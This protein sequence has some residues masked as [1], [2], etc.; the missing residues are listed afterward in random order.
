MW[1]R[2]HEAPPSERSFLQYWRGSSV[3]KSTSLSAR[4]C[5]SFLVARARVI[6]NDCGADQ[7]RKNYR[8]RSRIVG[9]SPVARGQIPWQVAVRRDYQQFCGGAVL[10]PNFVVTTAH[11]FRKE[12]LYEISAGI[13]DVREA[14]QFRSIVKKILHPS[15]RYGV[16]ENDIALLRVNESFRFDALTS[17]LCLPDSDAT[18]KVDSILV[19]GWG[20]LREGYRQPNILHSVVLETASDERCKKRFPYAFSSRSMFCALSDN[21]DACQGDSGAAAVTFDVNR[22]ASVLVG[23]V[24]WGRGC[25]RNDT[26]GVY[27]KIQSFLPWIR[28]TINIHGDDSDRAQ[29]AERNR[30]VICGG[31]VVAPNFVL[32]AAHC[33]ADMN[34]KTFQLVTGAL[35]KEDVKRFIVHPS[36]KSNVM[37]LKHDV[38]LVQVNSSFFFDPSTSPACLPS[39]E[40]WDQSAI[41]LL[42]VSGFGTTTEQGELSSQLLY[43]TVPVISDS[44]CKSI[45]PSLFDNSTMFCAKTVEGGRDSCQGDSGGPAVVEDLDKFHVSGIVSWGLGCGRRKYPGVYTKVAKYLPWISANIMHF[46]SADDSELLAQQFT[47]GQMAKFRS[48]AQNLFGS[49]SNRNTQK[50]PTWL[51]SVFQTMISSVG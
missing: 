18:L 34:P 7:V 22:G 29:M 33:I 28:E 16:W 38:A 5:E 17:P 19:S 41:K 1:L 48:Y 31:A 44:E 39:T 36:W 32:T 50:D 27:T 2:L 12:A 47:P 6:A 21:K 46:G 13:I 25:A 35:R 49:D 24:S 42:S 40:N 30:R 51:N 37:S 8:R 14:G 4:P 20:R 11:C 43:T 9:G 23:L 15:W 10:S 45:Y 3:L 26:P